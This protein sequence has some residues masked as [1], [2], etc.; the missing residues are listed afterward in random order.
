ML[1]ALKTPLN[2]GLSEAEHQFKPSQSCEV[3]EFYGTKWESIQP[4]SLP[5]AASG[6]DH[7]LLSPP[8][9]LSLSQDI[10]DLPGGEENKRIKSWFL[11]LKNTVQSARLNLEGTGMWWLFSVYFE[12]EQGHFGSQVP[13]PRQNHKAHFPGVSS[14]SWVTRPVSSVAAGLAP[15]PTI[16]EH[17]PK[18][19]PVARDPRP[20]PNW[21][22]MLTSSSW[23]LLFFKKWMLLRNW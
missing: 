7:C 14:L 5:P 18:V 19:P 16:T 2:L 1:L 17:P 23:T 13:K 6:L 11:S 3:Q 22:K 4:D 12:E 20:G 15:T 10:L 9:S 21:S 8:P